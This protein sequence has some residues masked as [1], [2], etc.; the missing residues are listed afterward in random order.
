MSNTLYH[1]TTLSVIRCTHEG[2]GIVYALSDDYIADRQRDRKTFYCPNG[3]SR[4]YP[5]QTPEQKLARAEARVTHLE[6]QKEAAERSARAYKGQTTRIKNR[7]R[8]GVCPFCNRSFA[9][10]R[11]HMAAKHE[12][13]GE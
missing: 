10:V 1:T 7:I 5:G 8:N 4:W 2:C 6:D 12:G 3:H 11:E 13:E 9:D